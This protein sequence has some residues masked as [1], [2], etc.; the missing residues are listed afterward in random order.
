MQLNH[1]H[2]HVAS[3]DDA[4]E[5]YTRHFGF[6]RHVAQADWTLFLRDAG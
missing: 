1:L 5:F 2:L 6:R 4:A 3:A